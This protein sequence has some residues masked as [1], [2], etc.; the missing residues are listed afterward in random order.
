VLI[1]TNF[2]LRILDCTQSSSHYSDQNEGAYFHLPI[3]LVGRLELKGMKL[4]GESVVLEVYSKDYRRFD[5]QF[6]FEQ[7]CQI[8]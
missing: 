2:R 7:E 5:L 6:T 8:V 3:H 1:V 4:G